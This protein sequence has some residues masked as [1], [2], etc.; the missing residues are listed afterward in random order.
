MGVTLN[1]ISTLLN[2]G[3][4]RVS[5]KRS[6]QLPLSRLCSQ[7]TDTSMPVV[8]GQTFRSTWTNWS[9]SPMQYT[10]VPRKMKSQITFKIFHSFRFTS[11]NVQ[12][13]IYLCSC[14]H[15]LIIFC[16]NHTPWC[17]IHFHGRFSLLYSKLQY[18]VGLLQSRVKRTLNI[19]IQLSSLNAWSAASRDWKVLYY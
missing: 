16:S 12:I 9:F 8:F 19:E 10:I 18:E 5:R 1:P 2:I 11:N 6:Q 15:V 4:S 13:Y 3:L 7:S 14:V 17:S